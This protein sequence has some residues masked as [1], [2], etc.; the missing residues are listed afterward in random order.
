MAAATHY[1]VNPKTGERLALIGGKWTPAT[2]MASGQ[3]TGA[4]KL[5]E[6][7]AKDGF[8]AK[9]MMGAGR[10]IDELEAAGF[11]AGLARPA[12]V[13]SLP[14]GHVRD[15]DAA[16]NEW[17]DSL[18]RMTTGAAMTADELE[19]SKKT[20]F[21]SFGDSESVRKQKAAARRRVEQDAIMRA[22]PGGVGV[23]PPGQPSAAKPAAKGTFKILSVE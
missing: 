18:L 6:A 3:A 4:A 10:K 22:G 19:H 9:R 7:Q 17:V 12:S 20:Y 2:S 23:T 14:V 11:D 1:A 5:T 16:Q 13:L 8:N 21:P 15:Y